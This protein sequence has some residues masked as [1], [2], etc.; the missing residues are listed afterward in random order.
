GC[1]VDSASR[2]SKLLGRFGRFCLLLGRGFL[3]RGF[4]FFSSG[5]LRGGGF[6]SGLGDRGRLWSRLFICLESSRFAPRVP[7]LLF[8]SVASR[9]NLFVLDSHER[10]RGYRACDVRFKS[11]YARTWTAHSGRGTASTGAS[12]TG[13]CLISPSFFITKYS[14]SV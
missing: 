3:S 12:D 2:P 14:P 9:P 5:R 11:G 1:W 13:E 10:G 4:G 6:G 7:C 8:F